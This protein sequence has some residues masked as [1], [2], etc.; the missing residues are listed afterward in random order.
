ME[1]ESV[2]PGK[3][4]GIFSQ[5]SQEERTRTEIL[6]SIEFHVALSHSSQASGCST[7]QPAHLAGLARFVPE[8]APLTISIVPIPAP[9]QF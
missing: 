9:N 6:G 7:T 8:F 1:G 3:V 4:L 5:A 2:R